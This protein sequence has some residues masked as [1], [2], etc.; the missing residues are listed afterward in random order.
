MKAKI[1][2]FPQD[3]LERRTLRILRDRKLGRINHSLT[4]GELQ[5]AIEAIKQCEPDHP[6]LQYLEPSDALTELD[7]S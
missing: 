4:P 3:K 5:L 7:A 6:I 2:K 1:L